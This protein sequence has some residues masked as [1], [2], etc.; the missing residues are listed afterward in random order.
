MASATT[1]GKEIASGVLAKCS[2]EELQ[3]ILKAAKIK[4]EKYRAS[5]TVTDGKAVLRII[6]QMC[7]RFEINTPD[8]SGAHISVIEPD[9]VLKPYI[10]IQP[11]PGNRLNAYA[12]FILRSLGFQ[13]KGSGE[14]WRMTATVKQFVYLSSVSDYTAPD[15]PKNEPDEPVQMQPTKRL[16]RKA[17]K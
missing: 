3:E 12:V 2:D 17:T 10:R 16:G 15:E 6:D 14:S 4:K 9:D 1:K 8:L 13:G 11:T 7:E 5:A